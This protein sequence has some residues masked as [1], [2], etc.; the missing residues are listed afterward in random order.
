MYRFDV[1]APA[2]ANGM[3]EYFV[4]PMQGIRHEMTFDEV[5]A[6]RSLP[7]MRFARPTGVVDGAIYDGTL[8][9]PL[10]CQRAQA[11]SDETF[12]FTVIRPLTCGLL[13]VDDRRPL[14]G[15]KVVPPRRCAAAGAA[16]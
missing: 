10:A 5:M 3:I 2:R 7:G 15:V 9:L 12:K 4:R 6:Y 1:D 16:P 8:D 14:V 13:A 11:L